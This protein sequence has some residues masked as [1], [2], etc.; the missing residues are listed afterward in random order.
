M[1][2]YLTEEQLARINREIEL[3]KFCQ[4]LSDDIKKVLSHYDGKT[5]TKRIDTALK[6]I[7]P[8]LS[9]RFEYAR[10]SVILWA[11]NRHAISEEVYFYSA[12]V[13]G[14]FLEF[15][16]SLDFKET[17]QKKIDALNVFVEHY[18]EIYKT[19]DN[20]VKTYNGLM[21]AVPSELYSMLNIKTSRL[22]L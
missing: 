1:R 18:S 17:F 16:S 4:G 7:D 3:L 20:T 6:K 19:L 14:N 13:E 15:D 2:E 12:Y 11:Y 22:Y 5:I 9:Y 10:F 21:D 8:F